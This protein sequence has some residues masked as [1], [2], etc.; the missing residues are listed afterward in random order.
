[1]QKVR[2]SVSG[3]KIRRNTSAVWNPEK[4]RHYSHHSHRK[5][6]PIQVQ[7][8]TY[9]L[10]GCDSFLS[11]GL[12]TLCEVRGVV[13]ASTVN[14][15]VNARATAGTGS[16]SAASRAVGTWGRPLRLRKVDKSV[17]G[18]TWSGAV[19]ETVVAKVHRGNATCCGD[20]VRGGKKLQCS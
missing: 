2:G 1:M 5:A 18:L 10:S 11:G 16:D 6:Y 8:L 4:L 17:C 12:L 14:C 9:R 19:W 3:R 7:L 13:S 15:L 20:G